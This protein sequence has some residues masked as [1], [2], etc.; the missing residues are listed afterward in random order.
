MSERFRIRAR[1]T[2]EVR[3]SLLELKFRLLA[4]EF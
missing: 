2:A 1:G 4:T 3:D